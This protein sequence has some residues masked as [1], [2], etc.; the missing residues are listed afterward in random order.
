[1]IGRRPW[2]LSAFVRGELAARVTGQRFIESAGVILPPLAL[3]GF[4]LWIG[5]FTPVVL[6]DAWTAAVNQLYPSP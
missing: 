3:L 6:Q 2:L 5:L 4:S 1:M